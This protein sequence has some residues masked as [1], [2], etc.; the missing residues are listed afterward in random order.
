MAT[1]NLEK[2]YREV[3]EYA[4]M[5][6]EHTLDNIEN[7]SEA[8]SERFAAL[9]L[10]ASVM[11]MLLMNCKMEYERS[12]YKDLEGIISTISDAIRTALTDCKPTAH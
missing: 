1:E 4:D 6:T 3:L 7:L 12:G 2:K 9:V 8:K 5:L 10:H 11:N